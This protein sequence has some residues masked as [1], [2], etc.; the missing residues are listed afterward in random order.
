[1]DMESNWPMTGPT[2]DIRHSLRKGNVVSEMSVVPVL[3]GTADIPQ[4]VGNVGNVGNVGQE[5]ISR[6][7][8]CATCQRAAC[9]TLPQVRNGADAAGV[10]LLRGVEL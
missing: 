1:M 3:K 10:G 7:C 5:P 4:H 2:S 8:V 9:T 6:I